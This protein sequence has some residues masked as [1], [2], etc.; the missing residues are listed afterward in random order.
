MR[1]QLW[2]E[3][4]ECGTEP[5]CVNCECCERHCGCEQA[6]RDRA[7]VAAFEQRYPGMLERLERH[8]EQGAQER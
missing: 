2:Q 1:G 8:R 4:S 3:C 5:V 7:Q 6:R